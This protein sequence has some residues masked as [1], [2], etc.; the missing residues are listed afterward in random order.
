MA[1]THNGTA[2]LVSEIPSGYTRP[3]VSKFTDHELKYESRE[4]NIAKSGVENATASTTFT[5]IIT[6]L[7]TAIQSLLNADIDTTGLTVTSYANLKIISTN[8]NISG[9]LYTNGA[10][11]YVCTVDIFVKTA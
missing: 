6:A 8:A 7:N 2:V 9:V 1:L 3:T 11:N 5:N 10:V 4:I